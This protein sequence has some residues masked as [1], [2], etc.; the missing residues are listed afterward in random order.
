LVTID[1]VAPSAPINIAAVAGDN[2]I[3]LVERGQPQVV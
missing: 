1:T 3:N 2:K